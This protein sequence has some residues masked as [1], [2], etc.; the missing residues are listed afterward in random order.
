MAFLKVGVDHF[1]AVLD[2]F[3]YEIGDRVIKRQAGIRDSDL[4]IRVSNYSFLF[5]LQNIQEEENALFVANKL[6]D[7]FKKEKIVINPDTNQVLMK[8][9]C[10]GISFYPKDGEDLDTIIKKSDIAIRE[11]KNKGRGIAFVF[12]ED[13]TAKIELF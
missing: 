10:V 9:I 5:L 1:K 3:N 6:I 11:A 4:V 13:E 8:T 2:E 7:A 12:S